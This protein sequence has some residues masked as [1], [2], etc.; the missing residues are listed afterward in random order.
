[1]KLGSIKTDLAKVEHGMWIDNIPDMGDLRL[2]V[3]PIG[4][5]DYRRLYGQLV[6]ATPRSQKRGGQI[7]DFAVRQD[8]AARA[9]ADTVLLGWDGLEGDDGKPLPY[10]AD[11]AK[12]L[13]LDPQFG[14]FRDAVTW[15]A[16]VAG[17][18]ATGSAEANAGN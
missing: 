18:E 1:M 15:A 13:L 10:S 17:E 2:K 8:I 14:A 3:R 6:E 11:K 12:E 4:N 5:P 7:T 9:L 16:T